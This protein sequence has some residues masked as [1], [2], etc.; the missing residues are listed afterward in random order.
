LSFDAVIAAEQS[1]QKE[2][3]SPEEWDSV[4]SGSGTIGEGKGSAIEEPSR[5]ETT[6]RF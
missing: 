5:D 4:R 2:E 6:L 3:I 1:T